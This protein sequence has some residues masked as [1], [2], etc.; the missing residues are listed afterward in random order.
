MPWMWTLSAV[1]Q[2]SKPA[3]IGGGL[4][5]LLLA[6]LLRLRG[7]EVVVYDKAPDPRSV[8]ADSGRSINLALAER[9]RDALRRAG[10]LEPVMR[11]AVPMPGRQ[12]HKVSG[13]LQFQPYGQQSWE[14]IYSIGR[15]DLNRVLVAGCEALGVELHFDHRC[16]DFDMTAREAVIERPDGSVIRQ[17][18]SPLIAADG[19]GSVVRRTLNEDCGF[20]AN[21]S[22][23][24]HGYKELQIPPT[25][26][27]AYRMN[28]YALHIWP[29]GGYMLIALPNPGGDFTSTLF[30][31]NDGENSFD[32]LTKNQKHRKFFESNFQDALHLM[33]NF[34]RDFSEH[35]V[36]IMGTIRAERWYSGGEVLL[37]GDAAHAIVPFHGQGMNAAFEDCKVFD[38]LLERPHD[39]WEDV[40]RQFDERQRPNA[41]AI[42]DMALENYVEMRSSVAQPEFHLRKALAFELERRVPLHFVPRYSMVMFHPEIAYAEAYRRGEIQTDL[43]SSYTKDASS[44]AEIDIEA[45]VRS[46]QTQLPPISNLDG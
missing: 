31:P 26:Y 14:R 30:L 22:L 37:M 33:P 13:E 32:L 21:E 16:T 18:F 23:L 19:A 12:I 34:D 20:A 42:A 1:I 3:I 38:E 36:G 28:P 35:R 6:R 11:L 27:G 7:F 44:L 39:R 46:A 25:R 2:G 10:L 45:A 4:T 24:N 5:G 8:S 41:N 15:D 9:G 29:R 17:G 43:L 40:F